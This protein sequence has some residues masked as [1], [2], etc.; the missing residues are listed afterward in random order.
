[1]PAVTPFLP[2]ELDVVFLGGVLFVA[3]VAV[4]VVACYGGPYAIFAYNCFFKP[5]AGSSSEKGSSSRQQDALESFYKGQAA[6]YDSTRAILLQGR[7]EM[8][9]LA[10]AQLRLKNKREGFRKRVWVDV[11]RPR[12]SD[13][14]LV[15]TG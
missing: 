6:I 3:S 7:E 11:C 14:L 10:A 8:M 15:Y 2:F 5:I 4:Y 13:W 9:A 12:N 1:M